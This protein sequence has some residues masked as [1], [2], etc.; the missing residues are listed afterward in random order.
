M[1]VD[2]PRPLRPVIDG[3]EYIVSFSWPSPSE[4]APDRVMV[5]R[6]ADILYRTEIQ[7]A[8]QAEAEQIALRELEEFLK[9][10]P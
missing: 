6:G 9:R 5:S 7:A 3:V 8:S 4:D 10:N 2:R 1:I